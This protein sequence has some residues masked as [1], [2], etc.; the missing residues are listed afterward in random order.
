M[1]LLLVDNG[2]DFNAQGGN[3]GNSLQA[4]A[5]GGLEMIVQLLLVNG[6]D[7]NALGGNLGNAWRAASQ[8]VTR[9]SH[10]CC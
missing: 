1:Q 9:R 7:V 10:S 4:A 5:R 6:A 8:E 2:A 3:L